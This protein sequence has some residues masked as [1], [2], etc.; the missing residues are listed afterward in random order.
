[1]FDTETLSKVAATA[2]Q[3]VVAEF[4]RKLMAGGAATGLDQKFWTSWLAAGDR[5]LG[6]LIGEIARQLATA[7]ECACPDCGKPARFKQMR[8]CTV[9]TVRYPGGPRRS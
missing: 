2:A 8:P 1:M 5:V 4:T 9:R 7:R 3:W 6:T